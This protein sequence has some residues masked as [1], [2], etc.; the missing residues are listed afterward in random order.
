MQ[1]SH[2]PALDT[3]YW[4]IV[5]LITILG[6]N[7]G[8]FVSARL[9]TAFDAHVPVVAALLLAVLLLEPRDT[10]ASRRCYWLALLLVPMTSNDL[11]GLV[12][13]GAPIGRIGIVSGL[14]LA[15][16]STFLIA[17]SDAMHA[18]ASNMMLRPRPNLPLTDASYWL[19][20]LIASVLGTTASDWLTATEGLSDGM[21]LPI[22]GVPA[23]A[24]IV[25]FHLL[26]ARFRFVLYWVAIVSLD[27]AATAAGHFLAW[28]PHLGIGL[29]QSLAVLALA[30]LVVAVLGRRSL[31]RGTRYG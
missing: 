5:T 11:A 23:L 2:L 16:V 4:L 15:L 28:H 19:A 17:R 12:M 14:L 29:P 18:V 24:A 21:A 1:I 31:R 6:S 27:A 8:D 20:M 10:S 13:S 9:D 25:A 30:L 26:P 22:A 3:R 7:A